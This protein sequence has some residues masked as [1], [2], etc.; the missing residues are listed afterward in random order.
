VAELLTRINWQ[1]SIGSYEMD[2]ADG[3][4]RYR[5]GMD[6][7][8]GWMTEK[9]ADNMLGYAINALDRRH[10]AVMRVAFGDADPETAIVEVP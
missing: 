2:F 3:E 9:M 10:D 7:E 6:L 4:V 8:G 5:I 1:M